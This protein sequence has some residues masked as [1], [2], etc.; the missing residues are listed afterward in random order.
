MAQMIQCTRCRLVFRQEPPPKD[1]PSH[2]LVSCSDCG[3]VM[4]VWD[5]GEISV[6]SIPT[7][8]CDIGP[9]LFSSGHRS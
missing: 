7:D 3:V 1:D 6:A 8:I 2:E 4:D 9:R 5:E